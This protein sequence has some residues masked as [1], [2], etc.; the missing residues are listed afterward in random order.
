MGLG[1]FFNVYPTLKGGATDRLPLRGKHN[2]KHIKVEERYPM[3]GKIVPIT[4]IRTLFHG[5]CI[6]H[7]K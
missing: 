3:D 2:L 7:Y 6:F 5:I 1:P 4:E